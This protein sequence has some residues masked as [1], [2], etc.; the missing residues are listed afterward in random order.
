[1]ERLQQ[2]I[3]TAKQ[4]LAALDEALQMPKNTIV[5][6]ASIQRFEFSVEVI[7]KMAQAY[8]R[9]KEGLDL[10]SPK[11]VFRSCF[12]LGLLN[13]QQ[14]KT[15]LNMI[16]DR[17]LTVHTYNEELSE[18]IFNNIKKYAQIMHVLLEAISNNV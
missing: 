1:M 5:R 9:L 10:A 14:T 18:K 12:N 11:Q 15:S 6:D 3:A 4:A 13:E 17:N 8:L 2:K 7:W 16:D